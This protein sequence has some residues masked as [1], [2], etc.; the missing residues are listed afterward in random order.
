MGNKIITISLDEEKKIKEELD[1]R[2]D[3]ES[4][5]LKRFINM[6]DLSRT[7]GSPIYEL[8][9]RITTLSDFKDFY[10]IDAPEVVRKDIS[11]DLFDFAPDHPARSKSDTYFIDD[12]NILRTHTTIMWYYFLMQ[13]EIKEKIKNGLPVGSLA[14]GK[15]YRRDEIDKNH[16]NVFHQ[17][18]GWYLCRKSE[19]IITAKDL[20]NILIKIAQ[21]VFGP[22]VK[23][24][25]NEDTFPYT[26]PSLEMEIEVNGR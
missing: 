7:K 3:P 4:D 19:K 22:N 14:Y 24:K 26:D 5:R 2:S 23:Y 10:I 9:E 20:Q 15:V 25:F 8:A 11:F 1:K 6:P 21:A 16:M 17:M 13:E 12:N 18:D